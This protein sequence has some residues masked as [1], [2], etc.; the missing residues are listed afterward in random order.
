MVSAVLASR[1]PGELGR[2]KQPST[3][4]GLLHPDS[5]LPGTV[6]L[7]GLF[8]FAGYSAFVPLYVDELGLTDAG[9]FFLAYGVIVL[10]VR[11]FGAKI[12]NRLG[13]VL[14]STIALSCIGTGIGT[15]ALLNSV[16]GLWVGTVVLALGMSVLF[17]ALFTVAVERAPDDERSHAVGTFSLFFDLSQG[18]G[19]PLLGLIV[20]VSGT[21]RGAFTAGAVFAAIGLVVSNTKLRSLVAEPVPS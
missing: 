11:I 12:P 4:N 8:G 3:R 7:L 14:A 16:I 9:P 20:S 10:A 18:L 5:I 13:P 17:P 15:V 19:A 6:L 1:I 21:E 2:S